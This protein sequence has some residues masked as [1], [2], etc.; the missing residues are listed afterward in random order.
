VLGP[1]EVER[2]GR[3][4]A[5]GGARQRAVLAVLIL[6]RNR[7]VSRDR[8]ID[9]VWGESPPETA[10]SALQVYVSGLRK[11]L[12]A[13]R[14]VTRPPGYLLQAEPDSVDLNRF[15]R[16]VQ[17]GKEAL[18]SGDPLRASEQL[19]QA[20]QLWRGEALE[21]L[22]AAPEAE[23]EGLRLGELRLAA[24]EERVDAE[25]ALGRHAELVAWLQ[26]LVREHPFRERLRGQLML[27]LYRSGRQAEA[28]DNYR[29][30]RRLFAEEL[31]IEP[32]EPLKRLERSILERDVALSDVAQAPTRS[33]GDG[34]VSR[35]RPLHRRRLLLVGAAAVVGLAAVAVVYSSDAVGPSTMVLPNS[36]AVINAKSDRLIGDIAVGKGPLAVAA[37]EG[38][39]WVAN[40]GDSTISRI[41]PRTKKVVKVLGIGTDLHGLAVGF[42]SVWTADGNDGTVTRIDASTDEVVA[43]LHFGEGPELPVFWIATGAGSVWATR[44][45]RLL[46]IDP[47]TNRFSPSRIPP[48]DG[49]VA[50]SHKVWIATVDQRLLRLSLPTGKRTL[51]VAL[52]SDIAQPTVGSGSLWLIVYRGVGQIWRIRPNIVGTSSTP[53]N[54]YPAVGAMTDVPV[55]PVAMAAGEGAIWVVDLNGTLFKLD[56][57]TAHVVAQTTTAPT[58]RSA[59]AVAEGAVWVAIQEPP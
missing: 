9:A 10:A 42:G 17:T 43:T 28:L 35:P 45:D 27:A 18:A 39:I 23:R 4:L 7:V 50:G 3:L 48:P 29:E 25:L 32:G 21:D 33:G 22:E 59:L 11:I 16:L 30:V 12:G 40:G 15:E 52:G 19:E 1:L 57:A 31:G 26:T 36:V 37:G 53:T 20:L 14:I 49:L 44:G 58:M 8:L 51:S 2:G 55:S 6:N 56:A 38:A 5:V 24:I 47:A 41:D 46:R 54:P 34:V 13:E